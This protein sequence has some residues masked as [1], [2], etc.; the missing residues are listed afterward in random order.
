MENCEGDATVLAAEVAGGRRRRTSKQRERHLTAAS[1]ASDG[2]KVD[3]VPASDEGTDAAGGSDPVSSVSALTPQETIFLQ[4]LAGRGPA[5]PE[6]A[7]TAK[8]LAALRVAL[9]MTESV[10]TPEQMQASVA[11]AE[12]TGPTVLNLFRILLTSTENHEHFRVGQGGQGGAG[13]GAA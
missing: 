1:A 3:A 11:V 6:G 13:G 9:T 5:D 2:I 10:H 8:N 12:D 4:A 7:T